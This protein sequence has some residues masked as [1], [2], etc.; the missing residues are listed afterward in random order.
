MCPEFRSS[1]RQ[2]TYIACGVRPN[3]RAPAGCDVMTSFHRG[4]SRPSRHCSAVGMRTRTNLDG[5]G[6]ATTAD[7][8]VSYPCPSCSSP[9]PRARATAVSILATSQGDLLV[10]QKA[11][12]RARQPNA[13]VR[14]EPTSLAAA[15]RLVSRDADSVGPTAVNKTHDL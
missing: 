4:R 9:A 6:S 13:C 8:P 2:R 15:T 11:T 3:G 14:V 10:G 1:R 12:A 5:F 7:Q